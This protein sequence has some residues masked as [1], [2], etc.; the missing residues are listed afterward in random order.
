MYVGIVYQFKHGRTIGGSTT[1]TCFLR[2]AQVSQK[3]AFFYG[4]KFMHQ[5]ATA[6]YTGNNCNPHF[7]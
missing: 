3:I 2:S 5:D 4:N 1:N 6:P 7:L